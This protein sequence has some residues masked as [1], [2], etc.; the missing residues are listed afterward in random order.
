MSEL[1]VELEAVLM[2]VWVEQ[3]L[4]DDAITAIKQVFLDNGWLDDERMSGVA[5]YRR[6]EKEVS[7]IPDD[8]EISTA[9]GADGLPTAKQLA[10]DA[11]KKATQ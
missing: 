4:I 8:T 9:H 2:N 11:A 6:F 7:N 10:L 5:W 1:D 3:N